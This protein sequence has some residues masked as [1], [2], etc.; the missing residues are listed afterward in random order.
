MRCVGSPLSAPLPQ[1]AT[2]TAPHPEEPWDEG[3][4]T[5]AKV[6]TATRDIRI[7][8]RAAR[9]RDRIAPIVLLDV[10]LT[11]ARGPLTKNM[12]GWRRFTVSSSKEERVPLRAPA[13]SLR[14]VRRGA[15]SAPHTAY[16]KHPIAPGG[17]GIPC[18][19]A[20]AR[21]SS[22]PLQVARTASSHAIST[23]PTLTI[24]QGLIVLTWSNH[25]VQSPQ[26]S[27]ARI[28]PALDATRGNLQ[29]GLDGGDAVGRGGHGLSLLV[30][31]L[32]VEGLLDGHDQLD[33][34]E[35]VRAQ[36]LGEGGARL[37]RVKLDAQLLRDDAVDL[38]AGQGGT[39][40]GDTLIGER[41]AK[42]PETSA[43]RKTAGQSQ[44]VRSLRVD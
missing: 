4:E 6:Q 10:T 37:D 2:H 9:G 30:R 43:R 24:T 32:D 7:D 41:G 31:D 19:W 21:D 13:D 11:A 36:V 27:P 12:E 34:V 26:Q 44:R 8:T 35:A 39:S 25:T 28:P 42:F 20:H 16:Y 23:P 40:R 18:I 1:A 33:G 3:N 29:L 5:R 38:Q 17:G 22:D 14:N 15:D